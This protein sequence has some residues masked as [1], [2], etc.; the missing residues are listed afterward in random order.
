MV[1]IG[2]IKEPPPFAAERHQVLLH[3]AI[4]LD[5]QEAVLQQAALQVILELLAHEPGQAS[6][7]LFNRLNE[8]RVMLGDNGVEDGLFR[9]VAVVGGSGGNRGRNGHQSWYSSLSKK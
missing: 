1:R 7:G 5:A 2:G 9:P 4:A 3:A 6:A 8:A